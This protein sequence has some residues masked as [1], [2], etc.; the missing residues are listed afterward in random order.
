MTT[1][2]SKAVFLINPDKARAIMACYDAGDDAEQ[3]M[4][5]TLDPD[6]KVGDYVVVESNVRH[7]MTVCK[8]ADCDVTVDFDTDDKVKWIVGVIQRADFDAL[9][10]QE[11]A[12]I[13]HIKGVKARKRQKELADEL[14]ADAGPEAR[15]LLG[16]QIVDGKAEAAD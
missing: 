3:V 9:K 2:Y 4:F 8:V 11:E 12:A 5:K 13:E 6:I 16:G 7:N 14:L 15:K 1:N 10:K